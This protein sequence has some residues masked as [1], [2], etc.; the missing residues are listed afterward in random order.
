MR[1]CFVLRRLDCLIL[2]CA[3]FTGV[4]LLE[5]AARFSPSAV[6]HG[7]DIEGRLFPQFKPSNISFSLTNITDLPIEWS[8]RFDIVHQRLLFAALTNPQWSAAI[9]NM[10]R[11]LRPGGWVQLLESE[12]F[13]TGHYTQKYGDILRELYRRRDLV[14]RVYEELPLLLENAG[15]T[16]VKIIRSSTPVGK[17]AGQPG[18]EG[19]D[20]VMA[21]FRAMKLPILRM[22]GFSMVKSEAE[23]DELLDNVEKEWDETEGM[24]LGFCLIVARKP[25]ASSDGL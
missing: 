24:A 1:Y 18:I 5:A 3:C 7:I 14:I 16:D 9:A 4:W 10:F 11:V 25:P 23:I 19:R 22:G 15:F 2:T 13:E 20:N 12:N 6:L 21:V 8:S 17:W